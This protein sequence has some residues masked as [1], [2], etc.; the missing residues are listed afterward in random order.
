MNH[1]HS[2]RTRLTILL[3]L[4]VTI[5]YAIV[6]F[7]ETNEKSSQ[8]KSELHHQ[9]DALLNVQVD[10][11]TVPLWNFDKAEVERQLIVLITHADIV[12]ASV[13]EPNNT[14][15]ATAASQSG[16]DPDDLASPG[17][18]NHEEK[19]RPDRPDHIIERDIR[20]QDSQLLGRLIVGM[21][22]ARMAVARDQIINSHIKQFLIIT[23]VITL[24]IAIAVTGLVRPVLQITE[25]MGQVA[26]GNIDIAIPATERRDE[27]GKMARALEVFKANAEQLQE[28]L[29]KERELNGLQRQFVSMVSHEFRTPLAVIDGNA[30]QLLR[31]AN[32]VT[33]ERLKNSLSKIRMSVVRLTELMESVLNASRLEEGRIAFEPRPCSLI[34]LLNELCGSYGDLNSNYNLIIDIDGLPNM[35]LADQK[36]LRQ[37]FSNLLSNAIKYSPERPNIWV[38]G[39]L[40]SEGEMVISVR[41]E[42]LGIPKDELEKLFGRF[43]RASTSTGIAGSGIGLH[44]VQHFIDLHQGKIKVESA[45]NVGTT[46]SV[47]LPFIDP[48]DAILAE[49]A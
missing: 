11:L 19:A 40:L 39:K 38:T 10:A 14:V 33:P 47:H 1:L 41:D 44:L 9:M 45:V 32:R 24:T 27:I 29:E 7:I 21:S 42:G 15:V 31:R 6:A 13:L 3:T 17:R 16:L 26:D 8:T 46:F 23:L 28:A 30:Q 20:N 37:A 25:A 48:E 35:I 4:V 43:F 49:A 18:S 12:S 22:H 2:I 36:L 34:D 5:V